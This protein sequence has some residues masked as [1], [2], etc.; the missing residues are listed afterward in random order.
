MI[1]KDDTTLADRVLIILQHFNLNKSELGR[2]SGVTSQ[3]I[4]EILS[5]RSMNPQMKFF[6]NISEKLNVSLEW[7]MTGRGRMLKN[8]LNEGEK[9]DN[10]EKYQKII[11]DLLYDKLL[12][13]IELG[14]QDRLTLETSVK[15]IE[16]SF[17]S[18][19]SEM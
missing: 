17:T 11:K 13:E 4:A 16:R 14:K 10:E 5:G 18:L 1:Y 8:P 19:V 2:I 15:E 3:N 9:Q 12:L 7:L 6:V